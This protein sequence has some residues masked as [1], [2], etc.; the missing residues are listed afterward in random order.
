MK[1]LKEASTSCEWVLVEVIQ[2]R[3]MYARGTYT[4]TQSFTARR[5]ITSSTIADMR[6]AV[7]T[8]NSSEPLHVTTVTVPG[9]LGA[10]A[11]RAILLWCHQDCVIKSQSQ[12]MEE[13]QAAVEEEN[14]QERLLR[15]V[16]ERN[17]ADRAVKRAAVNSRAEVPTVKTEHDDALSQV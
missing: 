15:I 14:R 17:R 1:Q 11:H 9:Q 10:G 16:N 4:A 3:T 6:D 2:L 13:E 8:L 12:Q 7:E 5:T